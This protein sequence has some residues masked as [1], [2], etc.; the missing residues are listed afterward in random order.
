LSGLRLTAVCSNAMF[1][2]I[3]IKLELKLNIFSHFILLQPLQ[4]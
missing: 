2:S 1:R 4:I 3:K